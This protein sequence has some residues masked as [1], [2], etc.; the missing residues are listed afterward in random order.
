MENNILA[1]AES[2]EEQIT[3][4][5]KSISKIKGK[6][7]WDSVR[8]PKLFTK[9]IAKTIT[10]DRIS[11]WPQTLEHAKG[12]QYSR[13]AYRD[14]NKA[15]E[16]MMPQFKEGMKLTSLDQVR[17]HELDVVIDAWNRIVNDQIKNGTTTEEKLLAPKT[18]CEI[19][20][21]WP[22]LIHEYTKNK[23]Y[24]NGFGY[25]IS[26][27][28]SDFGKL[29][30]YDTRFHDLNDENMPID[31]ANADIILM[32]H[33]LEHLYN[34]FQ[35]IIKL[36]QSVKKNALLHVEIPIGRDNPQTQYGHLFGFYEN[37]LEKYFSQ[38]GFKLISITK[39]ASIGGL[40]NE[41]I[42]AIS[43]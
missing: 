6:D 19:G 3:S 15:S 41:R 42:V 30:G 9:K 5:L 34:P 33:V 39:K 36:K 27:I 8:N 24:S 37:D 20:F 11:M 26:K 13:G 31:L 17:I 43:V 22:R 7:N 40:H 1:N 16:D 21:R 4:E 28:N 25:D 38:A 10:G 23:E 2:L 14:N 12:L 32:Y 29:M 35:A 18:M